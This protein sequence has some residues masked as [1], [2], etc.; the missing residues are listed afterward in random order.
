MCLL[1]AIHGHRVLIAEGYQKEEKVNSVLHIAYGQ[2]QKDKSE[3]LAGARNKL[4][5]PSN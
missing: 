4:N 5:N 2:Q 1:N 3:I